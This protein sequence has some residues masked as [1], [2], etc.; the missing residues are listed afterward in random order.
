MN[1]TFSS[2]E[3]GASLVEALVTIAILGVVVVSFVAAM[4]TGALA[5]GQSNEE[6]VAQGLVRTQLENT[7]SQAYVP[8]AAT[9]PTVTT[10]AGYAISV[11]VATTPDNNANIQKVTVTVTRGSRTVANVVDYKV[12]R[13]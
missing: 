13:V 8:G 7:K 5:A 10:P 9:Y 11:A 2:R 3:K 4:S 12:N 6:A 1:L